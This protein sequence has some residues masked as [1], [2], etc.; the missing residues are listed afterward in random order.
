MNKPVGVGFIGS[1]FISVIHA[2]ALKRNQNARLVGVASPTPGHAEGFARDYDVPQHFTDYREML[3]LDEIDMVAIGT[4]NNTHCQLTCDEAAAGKHIVLEKPMCLSMAEADRMVEACD[5]AGVKFMYA[6][7]LCFSPKYGRMKELLDSGALGRPTLVKQSETH[8]GPHAPHF[9][10]VE[11]SGG[12]VLVDMGCHG[13][14]F[15]RWMLGRPKITSVYAQ[16]S[17]QLHSDK[18]KA[19]DNA[20]LIL[21]FDNGCTFLNETSW[22]KGGGMDDRAEVHGTEGV[23]YANLLQGNSVIT[24]SRPG[25]EY[26]VEK[27]GGTQGWTFTIYEEEWNYGFWGEFDHFVDCVQNDK[28]PIVTGRDARAV[29]EVLFAAYESAREGRKV[30][31]PFRSDA[32][33]PWDLWGKS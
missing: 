2:R 5:K 24:Y 10:D 7:E 18:T 9:W 23:C 22:T 8:D 1:Q 3:K 30:M 4:P 27:G 12:G 29:M 14:E 11:Q 32:A 28:E 15:S 16:L 25:Y 31:L 19:E 20:L 33:K 26:A 21:E 6:E 17:T 13:I